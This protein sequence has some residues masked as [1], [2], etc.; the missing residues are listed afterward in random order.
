[1]KLLLRIVGLVLLLF[2][3]YVGVVLAYGT[4]N[5]FVPEQQLTLAPEQVS[6][7][8]LI[9]DTLL[10]FVSWN[11]GFGG[12][13]AESD[14]FYDDG[15]FFFAN[16]GTVISDRE[17]VEKNVRGMTAFAAST[18]ADFFLL[19][20]VDH[21]SK[22]SYFI[23]Q[24]EALRNQLPDYAAVFATNFRNDRIPLPIAEPWR[25]YGAVESGL[26]S[27]S[28]WQPTT[29]ERIQ[30]PGEFPW[31]TKLFQLDRCLL[32]QRFPTADGKGLTV[33]N[34]HL[35]A[36]DKGGEL[37]AAQMEFLGEWL[38]KEYA[39]GHY[40]VAG[41]DWNQV[42]PYFRFDSF[43]PG[44]TDGYTQTNIRPEFLP[45]DWTWVYDAATPTNRKTRTAYVK[46]ETFETLIDFFVIS[47]NLKVRRARGIQQDFQFSDHQPV[48]MEV[49]L[50]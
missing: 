6:A 43:M 13:G 48:Y 20:E 25:V 49:E 3:L 12:L 9:S 40:V 11:V 33:V 47:P 27:L 22:R 32:V 50:N 31:P 21:A 29:S 41:G 15:G 14:F 1:M 10:T 37:K 46:G 16:G 2:L 42:P 7:Q 18:A 4:A 45:A 23:D 35:S 34:L 5:D 24:F 17:L 44:R 30:L 26:A 19:Q 28:R 38:R 8:P 39:Q 36:Y